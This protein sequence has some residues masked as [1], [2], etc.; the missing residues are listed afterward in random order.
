MIKIITE[1]GFCFGVK[2]AIETINKASKTYKNVYL[3]HPLIHNKIE[4]EK[5]M[6]KNHANF[7]TENYK[8]ESACLVLSAHG[9]TLIEKSQYEKLMDVI[10][11]TCPL[12]I[13]RYK[14]IPKY[15]ENISFI[16]LGKKNHQETLGFLSHFNYFTLLTKEDIDSH[17]SSMSFKDKIV[18]IPQTTISKE[19]YEYFYEFLKERG[20]IIYSLPICNSYASRASKA[21]AYLKNVECYNSYFIVVGDKSSSNANEIY[22]SIKTNLPKLQGQIA[23]CISEINREDI[24]GKDIY[25]TS[26]TSVSQEMV[27]ELFDSLNQIVNKEK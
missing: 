25:I 19:I 11:A 24:K 6:K 5:I 26:A 3:S 15:D 2:H 23:L 12:I 16:Y 22:N 9:H 27:E 1:Y 7:F 14:K 4:N 20:E 17:L 13:E 8:K 10:D 21:I 18:Y